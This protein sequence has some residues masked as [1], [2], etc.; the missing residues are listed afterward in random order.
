M[1]QAVDHSEQTDVVNYC[2]C[3]SH[4]QKNTRAKPAVNECKDMVESN[5]AAPLLATLHRGSQLG[6]SA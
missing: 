4:D 3:Q 1:T 6:D 5:C 2:L